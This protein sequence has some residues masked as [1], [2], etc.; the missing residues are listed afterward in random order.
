MG[1]NLLLDTDILIDWVNGMPWTR[2]LFRLNTDFYFSS[3]SYKE[4][5]SKPGLSDS[6]RKTLISL[7]RRLR[8]LPL[9]AAI[10]SRASELLSRYKSRGLRKNDALIAATAWAKGLTL[11]TRNRKHFEFIREISL[12]P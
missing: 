4:L 7:F 12:R 1:K 9:N 5:L 3:I 8:W 6:E 11:F 2:D 10:A